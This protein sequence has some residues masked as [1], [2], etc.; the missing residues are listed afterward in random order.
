MALN[1]CI[2]VVPTNLQRISDI[3]IQYDNQIR[4][5]LQFNRN[6]ATLENSFRFTPVHV[7][8][9]WLH[10]HLLHE[11]TIS[12]KYGKHLKFTCFLHTIY[13]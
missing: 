1:S 3:Q 7:E 12:L 5:A 6:M 11:T 9:A 13:N 4:T 10:K 8:F 2:V